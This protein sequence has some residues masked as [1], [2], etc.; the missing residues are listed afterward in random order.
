M[1]HF[2]EEHRLFRAAVRRFVEEEIVPH[3]DEWEERERIPR[4]LFRRLGELGFLGVEYPEEYGGGGADFWM[5]VALAEEL[6]RCRSGG[7]AFSVIVHTDMSSPWLA[8]LGTDEQK[9]RYLPGIVSGETVCALAI[10]EPG[11]GSDMAGIETRAAEDGDGWLLTGSKTF[12]TNGVYGDLY[13]VSAL[14]GEAG[15]RH[16]RISQFLVE[17]GTPGLSVAKKLRKTGM[18]SSDTAELVFERVRV[19]GANLLGRL[20]RGFHQLAAGLQ[21]ERL[22]AAVLSV[23][24]AAQAL[25]DTRAY[26]RGREAFGRPLAE[27][28]ALRHRFADLATRLEAARRLTYHAASRFAAGEDARTEVS[29]AKLYATEAANR[30][31]YE[32]VQLH[33]GYGYVR[34]TPVERFARDYRLWAIAAGSS[35]IMRE[36]ISKRLLDDPEGGP[37][38]ASPSG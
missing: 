16:R 12:T 13:F 34:E 33:G 6:A 35:E 31:A 38:A 36:I 8:D 17:R 18:L 3:V 26:L 19:P 23:S 7:V 14:T 22:L 21:R 28:Q 30:V 32:A 37:E 20:G 27:M 10:T 2:G 25:D 29:M 9:A 11:A 4:E 15:P 1:E 5:T 24:A